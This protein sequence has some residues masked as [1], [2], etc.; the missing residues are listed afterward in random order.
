MRMEK[1]A[2][3]RGALVGATLLALSC[4]QTGA[5]T[6]AEQSGG[7]QKNLVPARVTDTV[8][9]TNRLVLRGNVHPQA[10]AE[11]N[12]GAVADAQPVTRMLLLLQRSAEQE[13]ALQQLMEEQQ[14]KNSPNYHAWLTPEQLGK[15][16]GPA[17]ADLQA[18]TDWL[19]P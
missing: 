12:R 14:A 4:L 11:F 15:Q 13:T 17:D 1:T 10:R 8:D 6:V 2:L 16:F 18:V 7:E 19:A 3:G 9:D 5:Q